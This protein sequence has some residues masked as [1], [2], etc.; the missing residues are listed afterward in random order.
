MNSNECPAYSKKSCGREPCVICLRLCKLAARGK[1]AAEP[2]KLTVGEI[3]EEG[4][5]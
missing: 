3:R 2:R 4:P 1:A 5:P